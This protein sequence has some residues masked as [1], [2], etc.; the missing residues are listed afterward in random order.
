MLVNL[1]RRP[2]LDATHRKVAFFERVR[3]YVESLPADAQELRDLAA[4]METYPAPAPGDYP[5]VP[6]E[7]GDPQEDIADV[8]M[9]VLDDKEQELAG[10]GTI[11]I[12]EEPPEPDWTSEHDE[13]RDAA[14]GQADPAE[15]IRE[16][17]ATAGSWLRI[18]AEDAGEDG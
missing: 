12:G 7:G 5:V 14:L 13:A 11:S 17:I 1:E 18:A 8:L 16:M 15:F 10:V 4:L 9:E 2:A 3:T 6:I